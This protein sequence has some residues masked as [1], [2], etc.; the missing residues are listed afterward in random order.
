M[1]SHVPHMGM[2]FV[3]IE[4][5]QDKALKQKNHYN[6]C[7]AAALLLAAWARPL[8]KRSR[9]TLAKLL[10]KHALTSASRYCFVSL[11]QT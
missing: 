2:A 3:G 9:C 4:L 1:P 8:R 5:Q 6:G 10:H 11:W 7:R